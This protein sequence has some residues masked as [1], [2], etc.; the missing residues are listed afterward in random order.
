MKLIRS[1][2]VAWLGRFVDTSVVKGT[3]PYK[4]I[5]LKYANDLI[6]LASAMKVLICGSSMFSHLEIKELQNDIT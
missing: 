3:L 4:S 6:N 1:C 5:K 2:L